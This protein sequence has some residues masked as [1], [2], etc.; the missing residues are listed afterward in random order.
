MK[1]IR[2]I[3]KFKIMLNMNCI[4][5]K[6]SINLN[7]VEGWLLKGILISIWKVKLFIFIC[8]FYLPF[9][10]FFFFLLGV[11]KSNENNALSIQFDENDQILVYTSLLGIKYY[12]II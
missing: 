10:F 2:K 3:P 4:K 8:I 9:F 1:V 12:S 5:C 7:I 11:D 6:K